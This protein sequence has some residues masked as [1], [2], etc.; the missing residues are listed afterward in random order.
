MQCSEK[1]FVALTD[2]IKHFLVRYLL[3]IFYYI[4]DKLLISSNLKIDSAFTCLT[5]IVVIW[6][7]F[8]QHASAQVRVDSLEYLGLSLKQNLLFTR[9]D[10]QLNT[11]YLNS[12][13]KLFIESEKFE[14]MVNENYNS[15]FVRIPQSSARDEQHLT[16]RSAYKYFNNFKL[17]LLGSSTVLSDN[18][19][20]ELNQASVS[21]A[22][23]FS[24]I[25][26]ARNILF[27][28]FGGYSRNS[29]IGENDYGLVYGLEGIANN[30]LVSD[31][32]LNSELR[33]R[34]E[35]IMPRRN[36]NR[37]FQL[38]A[39]NYFDVNVSNTINFL[40][41]QSRKDFYFLTDTST[42]QKFGIRNNIQ[43]RTESIYSL[44]NRLN[45]DKI[46]NVLSMNITGRVS[47]RSVDRDT[48]YKNIDFVSTSIFDTKIEE[49]KLDLETVARYTSVLFDGQ[50]RFSF[51]E[52]DEKNIT[53][54]F[55][56]AE[57]S[58]FEQRSEIES[59][60][61]NNSGRLT[62]T[63]FGDLKISEK[64]KLTL[65]YFQ[66]K[67]KYD[68]PSN[69]N[70]DD[71]DEILSIVRLRY[72]KFLNP[73]FEAFVSAEGTYSH[74]V[75]IFAGRS[76]NNNINRILRLKAG[77]DYRGSKISSYNSFEVSAN[78][79]VYDFEDLTSNFQ[80][81]SFRQ[82][83]A[84]DSTTIRLTDRIS[85]FAYGSVK[86][87]EQG[88]FRWSSFTSRPTRFLQEIYMEPRIIL[89]LERSS[90]SAGIRYF[91]LDTYSFNKLTK[92]ADTEY[93][94]FGPI[95][96]INVNVWRRVNIYLNGFYEFIRSSGNPSRELANLIL[97]VNWKF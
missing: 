39:A 19:R 12:G 45:Y 53:K 61:N 51:S 14:L 29:Q 31:F 87:S 1:S 49:L 16:L 65:S 57:Q 71:R 83:T 92:I 6:L 88:D 15:T 76:S 46:F 35:D 67:L 81:F 96:V 52:R 54:P 21:F 77:G 41:S 66:S 5:I 3:F 4:N 32:R 94:S 59:Q 34:N 20:L 75:Y 60:K 10:K 50:L 25:E 2:I 64:D 23:L 47:M 56:N 22:T 73:Y 91:S 40:Y 85:L 80:S 79:T 82:M 69:Q 72:T 74:I 44:Q 28:P 9:F 42:Q 7:C 24:E 26:P 17:G 95:A 68:T 93:S 84:L 37:Y 27:S 90:L 55:E 58:L 11:F 33:L 63:F 89:Y 62:L 86:L 18:R 36:L 43:S 13:L 78:Y 48:R 38:S 97:E 8:W 70:D 30:L